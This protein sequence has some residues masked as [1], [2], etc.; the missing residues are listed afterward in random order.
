MART[1]QQAIQRTVRRLSDK[2]K[3]AGSLVAP[4][5][6]LEDGTYDKDVNIP[7]CEAHRTLGQQ[8]GGGVQREMNT[9]EPKQRKGPHEGGRRL[10]SG[11]M[12][13]VKGCFVCGRNIR[14]NDKKTR[15]EVSTAI[16]RLTEN[17][18]TALL[19]VTDLDEIQ[20]M[21]AS[22][23][24]ATEPTGE[25]AQWADEEEDESDQ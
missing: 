3:T 17:H 15:E 23:Q 10:K 11:W 12:R 25:G 7:E 21:C 13:G 1:A 24:E 2:S 16:R 18:P 14:S 6:G 22:D 19:S 20:T 4:L 9:Y 5:V 8:D